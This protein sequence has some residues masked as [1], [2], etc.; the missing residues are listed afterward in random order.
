VR[1]DGVMDLHVMQVS[2]CAGGWGYG[3]TCNAGVCTCRWMGLW[4]YL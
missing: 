2:V 3:S 4:M 1:V